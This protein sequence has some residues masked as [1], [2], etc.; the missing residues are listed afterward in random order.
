MIAVM[1]TILAK[2]LNKRNVNILNKFLKCSNY[3]KILYQ[4]LN[5]DWINVI[6]P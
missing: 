6:I 5:L 3:N 4:L 2:K 1:N